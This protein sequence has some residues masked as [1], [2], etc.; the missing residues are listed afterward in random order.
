MEIPCVPL[1]ARGP[2]LQHKGEPQA[3]G[4]RKAGD[5]DVPW[6]NPDGLGAGWEESRVG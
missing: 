6:K 1:C 3:G 4:L 5:P 2:H